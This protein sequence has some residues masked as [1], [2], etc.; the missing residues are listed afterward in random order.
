MKIKIRANDQVNR[1]KLVIAL[2]NL[3]Y[4]VK[5]ETHFNPITFSE[6]NN[7]AVNIDDKI[8]IQ[9]ETT[10][11]KAIVVIING[12]A[13]NIESPTLTFQDIIYAYLKDKKLYYMGFNLHGTIDSLASWYNSYKVIFKTADGDVEE[14]LKNDE[15]ID[16]EDGLIITITKKE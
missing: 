13:F 3:G 5:V 4:E 9:S 6:E 7:V 2:A 15:F 12:E 14:E 10:D 1:E 11:F 8:T 16:I